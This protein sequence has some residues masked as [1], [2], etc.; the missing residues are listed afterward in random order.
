MGI[1]ENVIF[2]QAMKIV[3]NKFK[4]IHSIL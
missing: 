3:I 2:P 1:H 4:C